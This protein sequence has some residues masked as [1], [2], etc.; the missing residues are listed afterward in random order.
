M[1]QFLVSWIDFVCGQESL[2]CFEIHALQY[3]PETMLVLSRCGHQL[4]DSSNSFYVLSVVEI[5][6]MYLRLSQD[7]MECSSQ[8]LVHIKV[9]VLRLQSS[10]RIAKNICLDINVLYE[11][12]LYS[13][14]WE[15]V[16][17]G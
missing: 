6:S 14:A 5:F 7:V 2:D 12:Y 1:L 13:R 4:Q 9:I 17:A 8:N 3:Q 16:T 15:A 10:T 11:D